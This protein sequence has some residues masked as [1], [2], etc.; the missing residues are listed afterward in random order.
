MSITDKF[1]GSKELEADK[2]AGRISDNLS[3]LSLN[4]DMPF[5]RNEGRL[6]KRMN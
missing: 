6:S 5:L 3:E 2:K 4:T 1:R